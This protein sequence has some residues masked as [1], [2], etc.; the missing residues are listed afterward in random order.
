MDILNKTLRLSEIFEGE[1]KKYENF[2]K[3]NK[4]LSFEELVEIASEK[5][6]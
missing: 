4:Q 5:Y 2:V 6:A 3:K 1:P